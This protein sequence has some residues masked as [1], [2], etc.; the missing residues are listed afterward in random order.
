MT[1]SRIVLFKVFDR[2]QVI[3]VS[4]SYQT[5]LKI[6][7]EIGHHN[8][9][10]MV[11]GIKDGHNIRIV[12][13]NI[14]VKMGVKYERSDHHGNMLNW[15]ASAVI[16]QETSFTGLSEIQQC[17]AEELQLAACFAYNG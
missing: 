16:L 1:F 14:N 9:D 8:N 4:T 15:F 3:R 12:G 6:I 11:K 2:L 7:E 5:A 10:T 17:E 13:D